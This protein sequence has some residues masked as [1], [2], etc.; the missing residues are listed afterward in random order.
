MGYCVI[1]GKM[2]DWVASSG[3]CSVTACKDTPSTGIKSISFSKLKEY[4][5]DEQPIVDAEPVR[6]GRWIEVD[7]GDCCYR[8]SECG[9]IRDAYLLD[10]GNYCPQCGAKMDEEKE[11]GIN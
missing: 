10:I 7:V 5:A 2:C 11:N 9:F 1:K 6:H 3:Y 8:C 4:M